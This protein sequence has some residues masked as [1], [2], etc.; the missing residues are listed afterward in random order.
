MKFLK[1]LKSGLSYVFKFL[2]ENEGHSS[3]RVKTFLIVLA[4]CC[5]ILTVC[6]HIIYLTIQ[7]PDLIKWVELSGFIAS[8]TPV[9][10]STL[11]YKVKQKERELNPEKVDITTQF[12][13][14]TQ[15]KQ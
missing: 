6:F 4:L 14:T 7:K 10:T 3:L 9:L 13:S 11:Y 1:Y 5:T 8:L 15:N 12:V 2:K